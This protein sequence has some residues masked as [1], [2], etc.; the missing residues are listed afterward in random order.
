MAPEPVGS[1]SEAFEREL[2]ELLAEFG[3]EI[4][5]TDPQ[6]DRRED[7]LLFTI[8]DEAASTP[9]LLTRL[10]GLLLTWSLSFAHEID[11]QATRL[12]KLE[13]DRD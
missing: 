7:G 9:E 11:R 3:I 10:I 12:R 4:S 5:A 2:R 13:A 1:F 6:S 8:T